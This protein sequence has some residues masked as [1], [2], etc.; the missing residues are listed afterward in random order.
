MNIVYKKE[1]CLFN[2]TYLTVEKNKLQS[3]TWTVFPGSA[4]GE[5]PTCRCRRHKRLWFD[6]YQEDPMEES[7]VTHSSILA[8]E[9]PWDEEPGGLRSTGSQRGR[10]NWSNLAHSTHLNINLS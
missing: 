3:P 2:G 5:A 8:R 1:A 6:P 4:G 9:I 10:L 7:M